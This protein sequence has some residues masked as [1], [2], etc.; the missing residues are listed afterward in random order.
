M[1]AIGI[2]VRK[3]TPTTG[4]M[5][6][7]GTLRGLYSGLLPT[8]PVWVGRDGRPAQSLPVPLGGPVIIQRMGVPVASDVLFLTGEIGQLTQRIP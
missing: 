3:N 8:R 5:Q 2:L 7:V 1:P 6:R 4:L